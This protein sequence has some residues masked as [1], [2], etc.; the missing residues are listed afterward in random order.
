M[1]DILGNLQL[2][3]A[4]DILLHE[5]HEDVRLASLCQ[6]LEQDGVLR[7]PPIA[8]QTQGGQY[9]IID[10]AHR[11][12]AMQMLGYDKIL[13]QVVDRNRISIGCWEHVVPLGEWWN[14]L[15]EDPLFRWETELSSEQPI[16]EFLEAD[17]TRRW[18]YPIDDVRHLMQRLALW[19]RVTQAYATTVTVNRQPLGWGGLPPANTV[20]VRFERCTLEELETVVAAG[21]VMPSGVTRFEIDDRLLNVCVPLQY[22]KEI[23]GSNALHQFLDDKR[24]KLRYYSK[25]VYFC[26]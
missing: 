3:D 20:L 25:S 17:G 21:E 12:Q 13:I 9:L 18:L 10:G 5:T 6:S 16:A 1:N 24:N 7:N 26:E 15:R 23:G 2:V 4:S 19:H 14:S 8:V 11:T 22:L